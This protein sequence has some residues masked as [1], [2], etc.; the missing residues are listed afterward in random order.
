MSSNLLPGL[1]DKMVQFHIITL[2]WIADWLNSIQTC[3]GCRKKMQAP[4]FL[5]S[6][7]SIP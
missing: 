3:P 4:L 7:L 1:A 5:I 2:D 6:N